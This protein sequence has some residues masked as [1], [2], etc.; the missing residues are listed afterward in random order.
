A[1]LGQAIGMRI[2]AN[3]PYLSPALAP[4]EHVLWA[5]LDDLLGQSD[6]VSIHVPDTPETEGL[7]SEGRLRRMRVGSYLVNVTAPSVLDIPG[8]RR[9][10]EQRHLAGAALDVHDSHPLSPGSPMLALANAGY[11]VLLTPHIGGATS[12]TIGRHSS[13]VVEDLERFLAGERPKR[14]ANPA[15]W[16]R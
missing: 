16:P 14:L 3:D 9:A 10:L 13:M 2:V 7:L 12:E 11:N 15:V 5:D 8:L 6:F 4:P 1:R